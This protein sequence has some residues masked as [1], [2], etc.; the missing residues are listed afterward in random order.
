MLYSVKQIRQIET[1]AAQ[2]LEPATLMHNVGQAAAQAAVRLLAA[3]NQPILVVAGPGNNGG[4]AF[5][6]A[7]H[8]AHA[9]HQISV[10]HYPPKSSRSADSAQA[11]DKAKACSDI[12][13]LAEDVEL[14]N[15]FALVID[16]LFGIGL[17]KHSVA[18][19]I[20]NHIA[21]INA[22]T[23]PILAIDVPSGLDADTGTLVND[24]AIRASHTITFIGDKTGLHTGDGRDYAGL[25]QVADLGIAAQLFPA[26]EMELN[27]PKLFPT[28]FKSRLQNSNKGSNGSTVLIGGALGMQGALL[29][30][31]RT[32]LYSGAGRVFASF[33]EA[34]PNYDALHPEIMC[35]LA[36]QL[37]L[38]ADQVVVIGPGLGNS[39]ASFE[40]VSRALLATN[41][42][43]VDA[44]ALNLMAQQPAL[45]ALCNGRDPAT[46]LL[47]PHPLEA[48]RLLAC[49]VEQIQAD[50]IGAAKKL[51]RRFS[52]VV[53][54]KGSG[55][56]IARP[57]GHIVINPTG[58]A[59][60]ATGGTGDV[61]SGACG[62]LIAQH[63]D[64]WQAALAATYL[65]GASAD[66]LVARG[67]GPVGLSAGELIPEIRHQLNATGLAMRDLNVLKPK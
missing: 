61:L 64:V 11:F 60:L 3:P 56:I 5:E 41:L 51:A 12:I 44:D 22:M 13:W 53:I 6:A 37:N 10:L 17:A 49:T 34:A 52:S 38:K 36:L 21:Q 59:A 14:E 18:A 32:A 25:V 29:L 33:I 67:I 54:L 50:R 2:Q 26:S 7:V 20:Q 62:G 65:H 8:L 46:T 57:D 23:C 27:R 42:L 28:I 55:S 47:T 30:A 39:I 66:A 9:G 24:I 43:V 58:N 16:G 15:S 45:I 48:A 40:L 63:R 19:S 1:R 4:D 31:S 35:S